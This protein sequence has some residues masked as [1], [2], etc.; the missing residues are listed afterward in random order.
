ML[1]PSNLHT[2]TLIHNYIT[3]TPILHPKIYI[4]S[5][6]TLSLST[7]AC[8]DIVRL[9]HSL[10]RLSCRACN[11]VV[12]TSTSTAALRFGF[13]WRAH[14]NVIIIIMMLCM[15]A[16]KCARNQIYYVRMR[17]KGSELVNRRCDMR[18]G[19]DELFGIVTRRNGREIEHIA[20][21]R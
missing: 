11:I 9:C 15:H 13:R 12:M 2:L 5:G 4:L 18:K 8:G 3:L 21:I 7:N 10:C 14:V 19:A 20:V 6:P 16:A 1:P 17:S